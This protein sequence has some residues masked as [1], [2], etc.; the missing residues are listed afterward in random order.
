MKTKLMMLSCLIVVFLVNMSL[1]GDTLGYWGFEEGTGQLLSDQSSNTI[2]E[3][4]RGTS[5]SDWM[6]PEW[7]DGIRGDYAL[8]FN[9]ITAFPYGEVCSFVNGYDPELASFALVASS[10]TV[11]AFIN[12]ETAPEEG[13]SAARYVVSLC[14]RSGTYASYWNYAIRLRTDNGVTYAEGVSRALDGS[15][16][17]ITSSVELETGVSYYLA[18]TYDAATNEA[19]M[20]VDGQSDT[21]TFTAA[22]ISSALEHPMF[23]IGARAPS[24]SYS[25]FFDGVIDEV[26][27]SDTV[28]TTEE[29]LSYQCGAA[30]YDRMDFNQDCVVDFE[31]FAEFAAQWMVCTIPYDSSCLQY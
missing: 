9:V 8:D 22:P 19:K 30:G 28:L 25:A 10:F 17:T 6:D 12:M 18:Y 1:N 27:I 24:T 29:M 15:W 31:D 5:A 14:D 20:W 11:E 23:T 7:T 16:P 13:Y 3:F 4:I 2:P 26:R 21:T